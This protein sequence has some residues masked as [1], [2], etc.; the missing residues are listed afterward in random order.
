MSFH[1]DFSRHHDAVD[2]HIDEVSTVGG[3][4]R[5]GLW[6]G[7]NRYDDIIIPFIFLFHQTMQVSVRAVTLCEDHK[8]SSKRERFRVEQRVKIGQQVLPVPVRAFDQ[9][10]EDF[11]QLYYHKYYGSTFLPDFPPFVQ[12]DST[13]SEGRQLKSLYL[14]SLFTNI[15]EVADRGKSALEN[16]PVITEATV[17]LHYIHYLSNATI[18]IHPVFF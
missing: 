5:E 17:Y 4:V 18:V 8:P 13:V 1:L 15:A 6:K 7:C 9:S 12:E 14:S 3:K 11:V 2:H 16:D 10:D